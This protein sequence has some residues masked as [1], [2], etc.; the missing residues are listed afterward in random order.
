M[1]DYRLL[2][3]FT[4]LIDLVTFTKAAQHLHISQPSLSSAIKK[5]ETSINLRL[6]ERSTRNFKLTKEGEIVYKESKKLIQH[7]N[8]VEKEIY[9]LKDNGPLEIQIG[10]I[11]SVKF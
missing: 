3:Y 4:T 7:F 10:L 6:I 11:D 1:M 8:Y 5:L 2:H 9:R